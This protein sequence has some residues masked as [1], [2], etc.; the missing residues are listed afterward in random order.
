MTFVIKRIGLTAMERSCFAPVQCDMS[1]WVKSFT[2]RF[3]S[4]S[5][6]APSVAPTAERKVTVAP[7]HSSLRSPE[8]EFKQIFKGAKYY[9]K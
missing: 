3:P 8:T 7:F 4:G 6:V 2:F 5:S 1:S 9:L